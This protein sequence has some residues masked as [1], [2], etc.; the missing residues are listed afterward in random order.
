MSTST[1]SFE[2]RMEGRAISQFSP[3]EDIAALVSF[4]KTDK[5]RGRLTLDFAGNG[6]ITAVRFEEIRRMS[7]E[8]EVE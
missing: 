5:W 2:L 6:G 7:R 1:P 4:L 8:D 3:R